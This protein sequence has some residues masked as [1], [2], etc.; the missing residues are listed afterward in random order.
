MASNSMRDH[1]QRVLAEQ[2]RQAGEAST[3]RLDPADAEVQAE[4]GEDRE[5]VETADQ[6]ILGISY[7][8]ALTPKSFLPVGDPAYLAKAMAGQ[9]RGAV[10]IQLGRIKGTVT[11]TLQRSTMWEGK[12]ILS[13]ELQGSFN[14]LVLESGQFLRSSALFLSRGFAS[15][16][17]VEL[18]E[19]QREDPAATVGF[20]IDV[21]CESTGKTISYTWT[22]THYLTGRAVRALA[23]L[24]APRRL[25]A[26][27]RLIE[28]PELVPAAE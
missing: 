26:S 7:P 22:V 10:H 5:A 2:Q 13:T 8:S 23:E 28:A 21:G 20:D 15:A 6:I 19:A 4:L 17:A 11:K 9:P 18:A 12:E 25:G 16:I 27:P 24:R 14:A 1:A 3:D